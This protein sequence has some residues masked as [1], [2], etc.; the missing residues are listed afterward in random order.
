MQHSNS[1]TLTV[2]YEKGQYWYDKTVKHLIVKY[3]NSTKLN[4]AATT[5]ATWK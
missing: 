1:A 4:S 5:S 3:Y 2:Q